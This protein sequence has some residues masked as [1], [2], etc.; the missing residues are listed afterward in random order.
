[1]LIATHRCQFFCY[2]LVN[3]TQNR[4]KKSIYMKYIIYSVTASMVKRNKKKKEE[5]TEI[6]KK[7]KKKL[8]QKG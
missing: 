8:E 6:K 4:E 3:E 5:N 1:M 7:K 2:G